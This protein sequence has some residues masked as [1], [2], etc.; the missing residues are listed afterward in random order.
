MQ[1]KAEDI[2]M[3]SAKAIKETS[4]Q[5]AK[6]RLLKDTETTQKSLSLT[7]H[8][9]DLNIGKDM[10]LEGTGDVVL[11]GVNATVGGNLLVDSGGEFLM[12]NV[13]DKMSS[14]YRHEEKGWDGF[15]ISSTRS[16]LSLNSHVKEEVNQTSS[17]N[18]TSIGSEI[19]VGGTVQTRSKDDTTLIASSLVS[20]AGFNQ[21]S[22]DGNIN[23]LSDLEQSSESN[24]KEKNEF[25]KSYTIGNAWVEAGHQAVDSVNSLSDAIN[26]DKGSK[27]GKINAMAKSLNAALSAAQAAK[28]VKA[29]S[30]S[31]ATAATFGFKASVGQTASSE[32]HTQSVEESTVKSMV[33][34][35]N[36]NMIIES[37]QELVIDGSLVKADIGSVNIDAEVTRLQGRQ[38]TRSEEMRYDYDELGTSVS[39]AEWSFQPILIKTN[40]KQKNLGNPRSSN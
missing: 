25:I 24:T 26:E 3:T 11:E 2:F 13:K 36:G 37:N 32:R 5:D 14:E 10:I 12:S 38:S 27:N 17:Y 35:L 19:V 21:I 23:Y 8:R 18:E 29:A 7:N 39:T 31:A 4:S 40:V 22:T 30:D 20:N 16:S 28:T 33:R 9:T 34:S 6:D 1:I 15:S